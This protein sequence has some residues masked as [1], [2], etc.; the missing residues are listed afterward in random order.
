MH[1]RSLVGKIPGAGNGNPLQHSCP[2]N[3]LD[4]GAC[5]LQSR[6][7]QRA[8]HGWTTEHV[9]SVPESLGHAAA[10]C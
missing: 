5:G 4:R 6:G 8:G 10:T 2:E 1:V 9:Y 3:P 7:L